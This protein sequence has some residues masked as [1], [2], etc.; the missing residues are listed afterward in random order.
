[1]FINQ[2]ISIMDIAI[3]KNI[4]FGKLPGNVNPGIYIKVN[5]KGVLIN[6]TR[7]IFNERLFSVLSI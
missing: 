7:N 3:Y 5:R 1:M 6:S 2:A 4:A